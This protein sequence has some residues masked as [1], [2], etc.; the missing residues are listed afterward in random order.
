MG[1][2]PTISN[3]TNLNIPWGAESQVANS[4][5]KFAETSSMCPNVSQCVP[6][7][8]NVS[9]CVPMCPNVSQCVPMCPNVSQCVPM[10]PSEWLCA[11]SHE[12]NTTKPVLSCQHWAAAVIPMWFPLMCLSL[13]LL[14]LEQ[15]VEG[16]QSFE[17]V[18]CVNTA[19]S[20]NL[21]YLYM[22]MYIYIYIPI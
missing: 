7:C 2:F 9:Q 4:F 8:P 13:P 14:N 18:W 10:C 19:L 3:L 16:E 12:L 22:C 5:G 21:L 6:M 1:Y 20:L 17:N 11:L 15:W